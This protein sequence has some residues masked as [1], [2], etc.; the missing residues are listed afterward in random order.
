MPDKARIIPTRLPL[1]PGAA[2]VQDAGVEI[3]TGGAVLDGLFFSAPAGFAGCRT[4]DPLQALVWARQG[5]GIKVV[6]PPSATS[7]RA[8][9]PTASS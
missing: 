3:R 4:E 6:N 5:T 8:A 9:R 2:Q 7:T 1:V